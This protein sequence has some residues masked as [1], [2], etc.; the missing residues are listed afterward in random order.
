MDPFGSKKITPDLL[1]LVHINMEFLDD[2]Y[3]EFK[4][5][6]SELSLDRY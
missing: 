6:V 1:I 3:P 4:I 2:R 5:Y